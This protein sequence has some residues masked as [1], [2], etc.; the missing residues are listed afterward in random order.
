[1][2]GEILYLSPECGIKLFCNTIPPLGNSVG[3]TL[4]RDYIWGAQVFWYLEIV[5]SHDGLLGF[6]CTINLRCYQVA[7]LSSL[8][9]QP[10]HSLVQA[11]NIII[12]QYNL[13]FV[14]FWVFKL[15]TS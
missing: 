8:K 5:S 2:G 4:C 13:L 11:C 10:P 15:T 6:P 7:L 3:R 1:M 14:V 12:I 9:M